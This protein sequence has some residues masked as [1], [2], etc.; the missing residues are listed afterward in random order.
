MNTIS[1]VLLSIEQQTWIQA[2]RKIFLFRNIISFNIFISLTME[3]L[4]G[5][6]NCYEMVTVLPH[7]YTIIHPHHGTKGHYPSCLV[8]YTEW[9]PVLYFLYF[10]CIT[11][12]MVILRDKKRFAPNQM[13][14]RAGN[15][16]DIKLQ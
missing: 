3:D 9:Q 11:I 13:F 4:S 12:R 16:E 5:L 15:Q 8:V 1:D 10:F 14:S 7:V 2:I 6:F